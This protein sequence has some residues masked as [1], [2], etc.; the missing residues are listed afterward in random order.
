MLP[1]ESIP[2]TRFEITEIF[3]ENIH[4]NAGF[5]AKI[6][7]NQ[8]PAEIIN[9]KNQTTEK[10]GVD[11]ENVWRSLI[12][13]SFFNVGFDSFMCDCCA[14]INIS[15][16][17]ILPSSL[18]NVQ[19][20]AD[21]VYYESRSDSWAKKFHSTAPLRKE[22]EKYAQDNFL[23]KIWPGPFFFGAVA[24]VPLADAKYLLSEKFISENIVPGKLL[25]F[26]QKKESVLSN[27]IIIAELEIKSLTSISQSSSN[28]SIV[29][30]GL[31]F[32]KVLSNDIEFLYR[33]AFANQK[34]LLLSQLPRNIL[35]TNSKFF[36]AGVAEAISGVQEN[37]F[38]L[39]RDFAE[40][41]GF[42]PIKREEKLSLS[43]GNYLK[44]TKAFSEEFSF[45]KPAII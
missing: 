20:I 35:S 1:L 39:F 31:S 18:V 33:N 5:A 12:T 32:S 23:N 14:P 4:F 43:P 38:S 40:K 7:Q 24:E 9:S 13:K 11:F 17:H 28:L 6:E 19:F 41:K 29:S 44:L 16:K 21:G 8:K 15:E 26:C 45:P 25:W 27:A 37:I 30:N 3:L 34:S 2:E 10:S 36:D 42:K 22:R